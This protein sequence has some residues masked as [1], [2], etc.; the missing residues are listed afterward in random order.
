M[1]AP[2][3]LRLPMVAALD[4][5]T[6]EM[7][8]LIIDTHGRPGAVA[9]A[10]DV[11]NPTLLAR[12]VADTPHC[13]LAE[14]GA[15]R[16]AEKLELEPSVPITEAIRQRRIDSLNKT[17][18][19]SSPNETAKREAVLRY[20]NYAGLPVPIATDGCDTVGTVA[21]DAAGYFAIAA[22]TV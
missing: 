21:R 4:G 14:E 9:C 12:G 7:D 8:A 11:K 2:E 13:L 10:R 3:Q 20:W 16:F 5:V 18:E 22:P 1:R 15:Q 6:I 19:T 17:L